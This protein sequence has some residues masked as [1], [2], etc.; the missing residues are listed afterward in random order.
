M[1]IYVLKII[2]SYTLKFS[3]GAQWVHGQEGNTIYEF[4][5]DNFKYGSSRYDSVPMN[6]L[7]SN[8]GGQGMNET[9]AE[10]INSLW[11]MAWTIIDGISGEDGKFDGNLGD[12]F[13]EQYNEK[14][15]AEEFSNV[16]KKTADQIKELTHKSV[17]G[18][19]A[20]YSWYDINTKLTAKY[21]GEA[22]GDHYLTWKTEGYKTAFD[23][24]SVGVQLT[25]LDSS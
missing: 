24:I 8:G 13:E 10:E 19:Y 14:L 21:T 11:T 18:Y 7:I 3:T 6:W 15:K 2:I 9:R 20:S 4:I 5:G 12:Y 1:K 16:S 23:Y 22:G 17:M 25:F